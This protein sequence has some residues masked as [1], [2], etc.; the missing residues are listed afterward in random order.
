MVSYRWMK[1][2]VDIAECNFQCFNNE[3]KSTLHIPNLTKEH[4]GH[5]VC[6]VFDDKC[7]LKSDPV[8]LKGIILLVLL[9]INFF[10]FAES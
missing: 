5:Y 9:I 2:E 6:V 3:G 8:E 4:E 10:Y 7:Q 1:D